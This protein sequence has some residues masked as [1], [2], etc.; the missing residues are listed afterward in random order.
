[1]RLRQL[2]HS[3]SSRSARNDH[4]TATSIASPSIT[5]VER[6]GGSEVSSLLKFPDGHEWVVGYKAGSSVYTIAP[7]STE[8]DQGNSALY[9]VQEVTDSDTHIQAALASEP[10]EEK[11]KVIRSE[12]DAC[13][14]RAMEM[15]IERIARQRGGN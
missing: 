14:S 15:E 11:R 5:T 7:P 2:L 10:N 4:T 3:A 1:M 6:Q 12:L 13:R 8:S 9:S